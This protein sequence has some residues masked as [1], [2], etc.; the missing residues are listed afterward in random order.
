MKVPKGHY[1]KS[2]IP[3]GTFMNDINNKQYSDVL[4]YI[5]RI[6]LFTTQFYDEALNKSVN[7]IKD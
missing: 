2:L 5:T 4:L 7:L 1:E 3:L 6:S